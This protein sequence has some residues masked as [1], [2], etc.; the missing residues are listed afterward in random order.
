MGQACHPDT[1]EVEAEGF[2][3]SLGSNE[4]ASVGGGVICLSSGR[5]KERHGG[6]HTRKNLPL[7]SGSCKIRPGLFVPY[8]EYSLVQSF[9]GVSSALFQRLRKG[10]S[11]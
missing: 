4:L 7:T 6:Q 5:T 1:R 9:M 11:V 3:A 10:P 2:K 8:L